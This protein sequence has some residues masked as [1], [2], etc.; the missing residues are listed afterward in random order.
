M[1]NRVII[2]TGAVS[3]ALCWIAFTYSRHTPSPRAASAAPAVPL[4]EPRE[5]GSR[6]HAVDEAQAS[7][8]SVSATNQL[9]SSNLYARLSNGAI[10]RVSRERL[11]PYLARN[12]RSVE[13]LLGALRASGDDALLAEAKE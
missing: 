4:P 7:S 8:L 12:R 1:R 10:A 3:L 13:A 6:F 2:A 9:V 11:E 5:T